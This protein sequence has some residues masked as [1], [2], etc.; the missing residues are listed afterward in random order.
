MAYLNRKE[1]AYKILNEKITSN[2]RITQVYTALDERDSMYHYLRK[3]ASKFAFRNRI[4]SI[5]FN[6]YKNEPTF[7][8]IQEDNYIHIKQK[9]TKQL[10]LQPI[11]NRFYYQIS[12]NKL[13]Y[14][15]FSLSHS[16]FV[17]NDF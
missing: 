6:P 8:A 12:E 1:E 4:P 7:Q 13:Y 3:E 9:K 11:N 2:I 15:V 14:K 5:E 10:E 17:P 16:S